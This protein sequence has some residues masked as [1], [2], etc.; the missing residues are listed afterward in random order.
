MSITELSLV[1]LSFFTSLIS[2]VAGA[3][4]GSLLLAVMASLLPTAAIIPVHGMVQMGSN[5][6]RASLAWR[7]IQWSVVVAF[8]PFSLVGAWLAGQVLVQLSLAWLELSIGGF[9]LLIQW[10]PKI[11]AVGNRRWGLPLSGVITGFVSLFVGASGPLV[12][13][14]FRTV[15]AHRM[16]L[17][18]TFAVAMTVQHL[19]KFFAFNALGFSL[20]EWWPLIIAMITAGLVGTWVGLKLLGR[21]PAARFA[22]VFR[23]VITLLAIKLIVDGLL[24]LS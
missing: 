4:G 20:A 13:S 7:H 8:V 14:L 10:S 19:P 17:V 12:A 21:M 11:P 5:A 9:L 6:G 2:A 22:W 1:G 15:I 18:A 23:W 16:S 3:G 24:H